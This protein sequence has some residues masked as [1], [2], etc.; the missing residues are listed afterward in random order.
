[1]AA[2]L[3]AQMSGVMKDSKKRWEENDERWAEADA[4][5][6]SCFPMRGGSPVMVPG[7]SAQS[8]YPLV[9][10]LLLGADDVKRSIGNVLRNG[11]NVRP[12]DILEKRIERSQA[13]TCLSGE[14]R[15]LGGGT[16]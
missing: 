5:G 14:T 6:W 7:E 1:M 13:R 11:S 8:L 12:D 10:S 16:R 4:Q 15:S 9:G 3:Q 2:V